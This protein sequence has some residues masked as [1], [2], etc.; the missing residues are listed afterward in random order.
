MHW[1]ITKILLQFCVLYWPT[2]VQNDSSFLGRHKK[3]FQVLV[4]TKCPYYLHPLCVSNNIMLISM[5][6]RVFFLRRKGLPLVR[7]AF[8]LLLVFAALNVFEVSP[9]NFQNRT[10]IYLCG[11][12]SLCTFA[13]WVQL[14]ATWC[15]WNPCYII[16]FT[17]QLVHKHTGSKN[18][19]IY[20]TSTSYYYSLH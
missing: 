6:P 16:T 13:H 19:K 11:N 14:P 1:A 3:Y 4:N 20:Y 18:R 8:L 17:A 9:L 2:N 10:N 7:Y 12:F 15:F 5:S